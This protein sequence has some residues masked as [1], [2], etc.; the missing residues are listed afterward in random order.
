MKS[1][2]CVWLFATPW[3][4]AYQAPL[5]LGFFQARVL[6]WVAISF[7]RGSSWPRDWALVSCI[8][9][10]CFT[11]WP[12]SSVAQSCPTLCD[13]TDY[14]TPGFPVHRQLPELTQTHVHHIGDAIQ[15]SHPLLSP[16][17]PAFNLLQHQGLFQWVS[18]SHQ[19]AKVL[20]CFSISPSNEYSRLISFRMDCLNLL[21]QSMDSQESS[22]TPQFKSINSLALSFLYSHLLFTRRW[23]C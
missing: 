11:L 19:V 9:C 7:S 22:P 6:E 1:L 21:L 18:S 12:T 8:A 3:T 17:P 20:V 10:R 14:S 13:P 16:S 4:V 5:S 2:S 23:I 15:P